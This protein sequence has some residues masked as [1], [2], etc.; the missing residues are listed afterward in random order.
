MADLYTE[1]A[2]RKK[3]LEEIKV[4]EYY[5][6]KGIKYKVYWVFK[7]LVSHSVIL[8]SEDGKKI[9]IFDPR[10]LEKA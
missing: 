2:L 9:N 1:K 6:Y 7:R 5:L 4:G 8:E 3:A 10:L